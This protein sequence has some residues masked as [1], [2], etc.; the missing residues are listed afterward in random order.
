MRLLQVIKILLSFRVISSVANL[1]SLAN[2]TIP[3]QTNSFTHSAIARKMDIY[4]Y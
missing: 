2:T 1:P 3:Y 4:N